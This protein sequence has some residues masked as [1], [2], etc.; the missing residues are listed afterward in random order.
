MPNAKII[1][2][3]SANLLQNNEFKVK[4]NQYVLLLGEHV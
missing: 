2:T 3:A 1:A 4:Q